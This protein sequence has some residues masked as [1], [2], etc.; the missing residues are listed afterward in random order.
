MRVALANCKVLPEPDP[1][2]A[3]LRAAGLDAILLAW[4][5]E[6]AKFSACDLTLLRA[7]WNYPEQPW[8]VHGVGSAVSTQPSLWSRAEI[9]RWNIHERCLLKLTAAG[10]RFVQGTSEPARRAG[11]GVEV[12]LF[13][14]T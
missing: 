2:A 9:V 11:Y 8:A 5:D 7:T 4:D 10:L 3:P 12:K 14:R 6:S 1:D 13:V